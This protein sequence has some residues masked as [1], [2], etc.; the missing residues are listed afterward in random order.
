MFLITLLWSFILSPEPAPNLEQAP[1]EQTHAHPVQ[2]SAVHAIRA[3]R[4]QL[5]QTQHGAFS[6]RIHRV[7]TAHLDASGMRATHRDQVSLKTVSYAGIPLGDAEP[8]VGGCAPGDERVG[9]DCVRQVELDH[10]PVVE[11]WASRETGLEHGWTLQEPPADGQVWL[12][13]DLSQ[14][15]VFSVDDDGAGATLLGHLGERW[16]YENLVAWDADGAAVSTWFT[17]TPAGLR[18]WVDA[19]GARWPLVV[20]PDLLSSGQRVI[21]SDGAYS[22]Y[23]G[24]N[25]SGAGDINDDGYGDIIVGASVASALYVYYGSAS[26]VDLNSEEKLTHL[27]TNPF[28]DPELNDAFGWAADAAGDIDNDG[29][30]DIVMGYS[31]D[32]DASQHPTDWDWVGGG[33]VYVLYGGANGINRFQKIIAP[34]E[35]FY[36]FPTFLQDHAEFGTSVAGAGDLNNDGFDDI[37][38]GA[39]NAGTLGDYTGAAFIYYGSDEGIARLLSWG[40]YDL[41]SSSWTSMGTYAWIYDTII[42]SNATDWGDF[43]SAVVGIG[44]VD[45]N[46]Y[47]DIAIGASKDASSSFVAAGTVYVYYGAAGPVSTWASHQ[48]HASDAAEGDHFGTFGT[49]GHGEQGILCGAGDLNADGYDDLVVGAQYNDDDGDAS[50]SAYVFYG[51]ED[52]ID[53][54]TELKLTPPNGARNDLFGRSVAGAGDLNGD[55][56][57]DIVVGAYGESVGSSVG[58]AYVYYGSELGL[59]VD[60][61]YQ[62]SS[63]VPHPGPSWADHFDYGVAVSAAGDVD[64]DGID[65]LL[66]GA[67]IEDDNGAAYVYYGSCGT[68]WYADADGDGHGD[69]STISSACDLPFGYVANADD[70]DDDEPLAFTDADEVCDGVDNDCDGTIDNDNAVDAPT[71]YADTDDDGDGDPS[72]AATACEQPAEH[73]SNAEDCNDAEPLATTGA[74]EVC[75]GADNDC[76]G[77][78]DNHHPLD[79]HN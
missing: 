59:D 28:G 9:S 2:P 70:C 33:S 41:D 75:D 50:G 14:G 25:V 43:G 36:S 3:D 20:D 68:T 73:V 4:R 16:R 29:Y 26:G 67:Y 77:T 11:W 6:A 64:Q 60:S 72:T 45:D 63:P 15:A 48:L 7:L 17:Q 69:P 46:G 51:G 44:D 24:V 23:F 13:V 47:P 10:G 56:F 12:D 57:D 52:G 42:P 5:V 34:L 35:A 30:D 58:A 40:A 8:A 65:D 1:V 62:L 27:V 21:A 31:G 19:Q 76:D 71:W 74:D 66:V 32:T 78:A 55:G 38:V 22:D 53:P 39:P 79:A 18:V 37:I 54:L 61:I 49:V